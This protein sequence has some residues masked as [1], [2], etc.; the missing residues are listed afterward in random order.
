MKRF[1]P[2]LFVL[3]LG[4]GSSPVLPP[5]APPPVD[6]E[7]RVEHTVV[8]SGE[9]VVV[10]VTRWTTEGWTL[11][12]VHP[13]AEELETTARGSVVSGQRRQGGSRRSKQLG[14]GAAGQP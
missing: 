7:V 10:E 4:C 2:G 8:P 13:G 6:V 5:L 3:T 11:P 12:P 14:E 1:M 9:P